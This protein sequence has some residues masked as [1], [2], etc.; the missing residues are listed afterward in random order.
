MRKVELLSPARDAATAIEAIKHGADAVYIG[1]ASHSARAAAGNTTAEIARV[2]EF[3]HRFNTRVYVTLNTIIYDHEIGHVERLV[4]DL[5]RVGVDALIV[6][7][8]AML[9]MA[10]PPIALHASTQCDTR[11]AA[12]A[13]FLCDAGFSQIV[14]ARELPVDELA[15]ISASVDVPIEAFVHGALCVCYS[16]DCR[17]SLAL[18]GRSA[19]R[20][21]CAQVCRYAFDLIDGDGNTLIAG[22]HLLSL[23][24]MNRSAVVRGMLDAG[25][26]SLKI[27]GRLKDAAYVKNITAFYHRLLCDMDVTRTS[28]GSVNLSFTPDP[29]RSFNRGFTPY[30][31]QAKGKRPSREKIASIDTPK[32][33][34]VAVAI[35][36]AIKGK[37][38]QVT[39][40]TPLHNG[41]GLGFTDSMGKFRGF[42]LNRVEGDTLYPATALKIPIG[43]TLYRNSDKEFND[44]LSAETATRTI[45]ANF[46]LRMA[47]SVIVLDANDERGNRI[48]VAT[49]PETPPQPALKPQ[50]DSRRRALEKTG[51]TIY[52][53]TSATDMCGDIFLPISIVTRLRR[54]ATAA[55]DRAQRI[56]YRYD[57]RRS[58]KP[59]AKS[60][61][62]LT[63]HDNV[64]NK[65]SRQYYHSHGTDQIEPAMETDLNRHRG[66]DTEVMATRYCLRREMGKCLLS[67]SGKEWK[68]PLS[69]VAG[70]AEL[71]L[72]FDCEECMMRVTTKL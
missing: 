19:N 21:E 72:H 23:R 57:Y 17:A 5:Y 43:T 33:Q 36:T 13:R 46:T 42:R 48:S 34:G 64:A 51:D 47:G 14:V 3:A 37:G 9:R 45:A 55:L 71:R 30:F 61:S 16:G 25:V 32:S 58:E 35:V 62:V 63:F 31:A 60:P 59:E 41:D 66:H 40:K 65:L 38:I 49:A 52:R 18:T 4:G 15:R 39:T 7:D 20:G 24:D 12:K 53:I 10:L 69:L 29:T 2:V 70:K 22:K 1:A 44:I 54:D 11:D 28:S 6:Q 68:E 56:N 67:P 8:M 26:S 50:G 27:E